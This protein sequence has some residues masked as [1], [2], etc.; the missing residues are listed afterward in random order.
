MVR[1]LPGPAALFACLDDE[2]LVQQPAGDVRNSLGG[3]ANDLGELH[4]AQPAGGAADRIE[5]DSQVEVAHPG[6]V[7]SAP[8]RG[9]ADLGQGFP[10]PSAVGH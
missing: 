1:G 5:N 2:V 4:A 10:Y 7:G 8:R 3:Q 9:L 6:Q